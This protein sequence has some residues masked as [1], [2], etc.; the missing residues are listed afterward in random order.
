MLSDK[1]APRIILDLLTLHL[2]G[3][4]GITGKYNLIEVERNLTRKLPKA[5][6]IYQE[7]LPK[8][9]LTVIPLPAMEELAE[10]VGAINNKD[11]PVL[12]SAIKGC[13]DYLVTGDNKDFNQ[14]NNSKR[15]SFKVVSPAEFLDKIGEI[16]ISIPPQS[17]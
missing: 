8:L 5:L 4:I 3:L 16:I 2:P 13:A 1:G 9:S 12:L 14:I 6:P 10:Y 7:Y 15:Y 11:L 17:S